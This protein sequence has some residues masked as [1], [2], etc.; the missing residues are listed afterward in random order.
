MLCSTSGFTQPVVQWSEEFKFDRRV[1]IAGMMSDPNFFYVLKR[2]TS[3]KGNPAPYFLEQFDA[4]TMAISRQMEIRFPAAPHSPGV[5]FHDLLSVDGKLWLFLQGTNK[6]GRNGKLYVAPVNMDQAK[7]GEA[8][9]IDSFAN[10]TVS[11][12][13]RI[14]ESWNGKTILVMHN[15]PFDSKYN[16]E[17]FYYKVYDS[18]MKLLWK[19]EIEMPFRDRMFK[20]TH[21]LLDHKGNVHLVSAVHQEREKGDQRDNA[22]SNNKYHLISYYHEQNLVKEFE[23]SLG[24]KWISALTFDMAPDGQLVLAGF[25]SNAANYSISGTF[26][27]R[28]D[29]ETRSVVQSNMKA[30]DKNFLLEFLPERKVKKGVELSDFYFDHLVVREDGSAMLIA[31]QYY[32]QVVYTYN[33]PYMNGM[34][35]WGYPYGGY[36]PYYRSNYNYQYHYNDIIVVSIDP[37]GNIEW[38]KKIPKRQMSSNDGGY[39]SSYT[40]A[41]NER[42]VYVL[43]NDN[44]RNS[45]EFRKG[46][47]EPY[48]MTKPSRSQAMMVTIDREG[49]FVYNTLFAQKESG[50]ILRPKLCYQYSA[51]RL[52]LYSQKGSRYRFGAIGLP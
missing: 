12:D 28:I 37:E 27:L 1:S 38:T 35:G 20:V 22:V 18:S 16:S 14:E 24:E 36:S 50:L 40:L 21:H 7:I 31:E 15:D 26:Y 9:L 11:A 13:F 41:S 47:A 42:M 23:I 29:P 44:P 45:V 19:K 52:I 33:D 30:F 51:D 34:Y 49:K 4:S 32:M 25:Y 8:I 39:Y 2:N 17:K 46:T 3:G 6:R 43:F 10:P 5:V 48:A